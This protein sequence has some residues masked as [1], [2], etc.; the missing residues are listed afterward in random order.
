MIQ[1]NE[2][3][4]GN[5]IL[6]ETGN[7]KQVHSIIGDRF[8][9]DSLDGKDYGFPLTEMNGIPLTP[10]I[11]EKAG[12]CY[13][14]KGNGFKIFRFDKDDEEILSIQATHNGFDAVKNTDE[15]YWTGLCG[16]INYLHQLQNLYFTLTGTELE[17]NL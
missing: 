2:L 3:R 16:S 4:I 9:I 6:T 1:A 10:E 5:W 7:P 14:D 17:I 13:Q 11:L 12:G 8:N 15:Y